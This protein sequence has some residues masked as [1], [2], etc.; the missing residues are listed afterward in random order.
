MPI[1]WSFLVLSYLLLIFSYRSTLT[2]GFSDDDEEVYYVPR[3]L[4]IL[5]VLYVAIFVCLRDVVLDTHAYIGDFKNM[6]T[7]WNAIRKYNSIA[8]G[9]GFHIIMAIFKMFV[10]RNYYLWL[11]FVGGISLYTLFRF[12]KEHS[13]NFALTFFLFI[14]STAFSWLFNGARQFLAV[15]ILLGFIDWLL[16]GSRAKRIQ[17]FILALFLTTIHS[18][19]WFVIPLIY[20]CARGKLLDK[21]MFLVVIGTIA[22]TLLM[23]DILEA[24]SMV[25]NKNY[26]MSKATGSSVLRLIISA[27][28]LFLVFLKRD[29]IKQD[30][31]PVITFA[32]NMSLVG[33]CFF[34]AATF[35]S[36]I[37]VGRMPIYFTMYNYIL[38]PWLLKNYY[39]STLILVGCIFCYTF[40]FYYQMCIAWQHLDYTSKILGLQYLRY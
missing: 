34:F 32:I 35:S 20:V 26:D 4:V 14:S 2:L 16:Y 18:S 8:A 6:P 1:Y 3:L 25:M 31:T 17:Y 5:P 12:Y 13:C 23:G 27:V 21:W 24:A 29:E 9:K 22:G 33:V 38:L 19:V 39:Y 10:S 7:D 15:C 30:A 11:T 40:F 36:G 28:P 37:L